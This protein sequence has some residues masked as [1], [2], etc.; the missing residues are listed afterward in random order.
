MSHP[1][2]FVAGVVLLIHALRILIVQKHPRL[3]ALHYFD[4][5]L[6]L[7]AAAYCSW[8][9]FKGERPLLSESEFH[10]SLQL[11]GFSLVVPVGT[12]F[13]WLVYHSRAPHVFTLVLFSAAAV[14]FVAQAIQ[15]RNSSSAESS[16]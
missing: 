5:V 14:F 8:H 6:S 3:V 7:I 11:A 4:V 16:S 1:K 9:A 12:T 15:E 13:T 10:S 2:S